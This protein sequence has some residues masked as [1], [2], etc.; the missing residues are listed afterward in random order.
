MK[1]SV[2]GYKSIADERSIIVGGL[3]I[4]SGANS[5]GKS[6]FMQPLLLI[7][8]SL[9]NDFDAGSLLLDGPN[10]RLTDSSEIVSKVPETKPAHFSV[11]VRTDKGY[12]RAVYKFTPK[13]GITIDSVYDESEHFKDGLHLYLGLK[14]SEIK[15]IL[16][17]KQFEHFKTLFQSIPGLIWKVVRDRCFLEIQMQIS[18][19]TTPFGAGI[20]PAQR[21]I[22]IATNL[23]HVPGLRGNPERSYRV[24]SSESLY[25]G[26]FERYVASIIYKWKTTPRLKPKFFKLIE[27][28]NQ[29]G[30]ASAIEVSSINETRLEVKI[31]RHRGCGGNSA[32][33]VNI[34][35]VGFGV[36]QTLPVLVALLAAKKGQVVY[37]EQPE[38]HLHPRA[39]YELSKII[40][41][42]VSNDSIDVVI[43]T[44]SSILIRGVQILVAKG[45]MDGD[46][47][48]LNWFVQNPTTGQTEITQATLDKYGAF[49]DW[50]EDFDSI[51]LD[52]EQEYLDAVEEAANN[53]N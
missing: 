40:A 35:D 31:S 18:K 20:A 45:E 2:E 25:P 38:L 26:S 43:E 22:N 13:R 51:A 15:K 34:A 39:Q 16:D 12:T 14:S 8:Q 37:I 30:L 6:S 44:H 50:P 27:W 49:G 19:K 21:L 53:E 48:N 29:L 36:S 3:T 9:E 42:A 28:L 24:A 11:S 33:Y 46:S 23:I 5:S 52:V 17:N 10:V 41:S 47:V 7:K 1:I 32:D 4:L